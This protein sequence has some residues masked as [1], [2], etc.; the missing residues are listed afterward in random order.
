M[1]N[2][3]LSGED[4]I[5]YIPPFTQYFP[6]LLISV[7]PHSPKKGYFFQSELTIFDRAY[8]GVYSYTPQEIKTLHF[9]SL[10]EIAP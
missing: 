4:I 8:V 1:Q 9:S 2:L 7:P 5:K 3:T 6:C 10:S